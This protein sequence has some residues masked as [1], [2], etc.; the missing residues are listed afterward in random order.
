MSY[1]VPPTPTKAGAPAAT[2]DISKGYA[3][4]AILENT[5]VDPHAIYVCVDNSLDAAIWTLVA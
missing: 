1:L 5:S 3:V 4:G 2:D